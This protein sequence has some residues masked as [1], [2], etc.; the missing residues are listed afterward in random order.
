MKPDTDRTDTHADGR[1]ALSDRVRSLRL[2]ERPAARGVRGGFLPWALAVVLLLTTVVFGLKAFRAPPAAEGAAPADTGRVAAAAPGSGDV[3]LEAKGYV[4]A[5]HQIQVSPKIAGMIEW[6]DPNFEEGRHF[7]EGA[8]LARLEKVDYEAEYNHAVATR[9]A[10]K[11]RLDELELSSP[12]EL[13]QA[14]ARLASAKTN[15][16]YL[17]RE[18]DRTIR[19]GAGVSVRD[20]DEAESQYAQAIKTHEDASKAV[21][22]LGKT[23]PRPARIAALRADMLQAE[24]DRAKAQWRLEQCEIKAPVTGTILTKKAERGNL[25][26]PVAFN[27]SASLCEMADLRDLEVDLSIQERDYDKVSPGQACAVRPEAFARNEAF[28]KKYPDGYRGRVSRVMPIAD[29]AKGAVSVRVT[30]DREQ[31]PPEE[32]GVYLKPEMSVLV[33]FKKVK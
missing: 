4:V 32:E 16:D 2:A 15:M 28:L 21:A 24:A 14:E 23:G 1:S 8:V 17:A 3:V 31:I 25:V 33:W 27:V 7:K 30:I 26:N 19:S 13:E 10:A 29:R 11:K 5:A 9:D 6:L 22:L 12:L 20:R 18:R